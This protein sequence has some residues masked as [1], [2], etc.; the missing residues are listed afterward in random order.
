[1]KRQ[2]L[3]FLSLILAVLIVSMPQMAFA[4]SHALV[5]PV[6]GE[7]GMVVTGQELATQAGLEVLKK[8]G[9]AVDAAVTIAF[10]MAVTLPEA[11]NI[12]GGGFML[13]HSAKTGETVAID[14]REKAPARASRDMFLDKE[15]KVD[16]QLA[17]FSHLAVGV[18]GSVAGLALALE[19]YGTITLAEALA[20]A[21]KYAEEGFILNDRAAQTIRAE[22]KVLKRF[23]A[24]A[25]IFFKADGSAYKAG[26]RLVQKD[27]AKTLR[28]IAK[29]GPKAFYEGETA[30]LLVRQMQA[31]GGLITKDD[32]LNYRPVIRKPVSG[33][34]RG[35]EIYSMCPPSSGGIHVIQILNSLEPFDIRKSGHNSAETIHL[36]AEAMKRAYADR[37]EYLGDMD[38]VRVP[39]KW[40]TSKEY[41]LQLHGQIDRQKATPSATIRPGKAPLDES[42]QTTHF[43]VVDQYGNAVANTT[44]INTAFGSGIVVE[45]AGFLLNNQ[46]DDFSAKPGVPN[47]YGLIGGDANAIAPNKRMLSSMSPTIVLKDGKVFLVTGS[48]GGPRIITTTIQVIMNVIDHGMN[49]QEAVHAPRIHHQWIPE[50]LRIE[51]GISPDTIAIL[52]SLGHNVVQRVPMG[53]ASSIMVDLKTNRKFGAADPRREGLAQGH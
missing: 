6:E 29:D 1:M 25:A 3:W 17:L 47:V 53:A 49:I 7:R 15:G 4:Q 8:G 28:A 13:V 37:S 23:P 50:E 36:M 43:S 10:T 22:E 51:K 11:G 39:V 33:T 21:I 12:G 30:D 14:Y 44:T 9:N 20:P 35:Y 18:P 26:E 52:K 40:L 38:F 31:H 27:L 5:H 45:G 41:A 32:L 42:G 2:G 16:S 19:K 34:Y 24:T 46:M 48:P